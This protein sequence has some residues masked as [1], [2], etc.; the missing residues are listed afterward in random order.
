VNENTLVTISKYLASDMSDNLGL[1]EM[2]QCN[3][4]GSDVALLMR[5]MTR[6]PGEARLLQLQVSA[7]RLE[8][9]VGDIVTAIEQNETPSHLIIRM[10]EFTKEDH[11]R[12]LLEALR[13]NTTIRSLDIS[14]ASL[15]YDASPE[16]CEA[17]RLM[18][19]D[20]ST[21]EELDISGEHAHLEV[22]RFGI[23]LNQALTGLKDNKA[24][25]ALRIEYQNLGL[26][27]ANT[28]AT[29]FKVNKSLTYIQCDHNNISLQ[30]FTILVN[31]IAKN[32]TVLEVPF[33]RDDQDESIKKLELNMR[34]STRVTNS[35]EKRTPMRRTLTVLGVSKPP[36]Q[37][38]P[39]TTFDVNSAVREIGDM[40]NANM[41]RLSMFLER[42][43]KISRGENVEDLDGTSEEVMR[44]ATAMSERGVL[45][46]VL[47]N[48]TPKV[49]LG[50][51]HDTQEATESNLDGEENDK[52]SDGVFL[53]DEMTPKKPVRVPIMAVDGKLDG[54]EQERFE[55]KD[56]VVFDMESD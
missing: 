11:F 20:N 16:T 46:H 3:L 14:K 10:I 37:E 26:E 7:N 51:P 55:L 34:D 15:P 47:N 22:T 21:L 49:E 25:K 28:L 44:P 54:H 18:F 5:T 33:M 17:L 6:V 39:L 42:N 32:Y 48:T 8:K 27:G 9:G 50:N 52:S 45:E 36:K 2:E 19:V 35:K 24:L 13:T 40:W 53:E 38:M 23:G 43:R 12:Q 4:T 41:E 1:L 31:S 29:V 56:E 30:G